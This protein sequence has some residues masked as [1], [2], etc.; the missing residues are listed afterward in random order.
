M[1]TNLGGL[2]AAGIGGSYQ[3]GANQIVGNI[4]LANQQNQANM[5]MASAIE[6]I[7]K[8]AGDIYGQ[9]VQQSSGLQSSGFYGSKAAAAEGYGVAQNQLSHQGGFRGGYYY[10]PSG[11]YKT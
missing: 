8:S 7:G 10:N 1:A 9:Y 5:G 6:G 2:T 3:A 11:T 4:A